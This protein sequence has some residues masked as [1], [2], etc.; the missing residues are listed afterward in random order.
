MAKR[1]KKEVIVTGRFFDPKDGGYWFDVTESDLDHWKQSF[2][3]MAANG[4]TAYFTD[5]HCRTDD[6]NVARIIGFETEKN[7]DGTVGLCAEIE[8]IEGVDIEPFLKKGVSIFVPTSYCGK[9]G[10]NYV[11]PI[12]HVAFT[13]K[14]V[15]ESLGDFRPLC[16]SRNGFDFFITKE[17]GKKM[18]VLNI[19]GAI[20]GVEKGDMSDEDF[21]TA[22]VDAAKVFMDDLLRA[23]EAVDKAA[24]VV[25]EV[26]TASTDG[27]MPIETDRERELSLSLVSITSQLRE[28]TINELLAEGHINNAQRNALVEAYAKPAVL[29]LSKL[30]SGDFEAEI[31]RIKL[32][33]KR[34][35]LDGKSVT[36]V[37]KTG[38]S[39]DPKTCNPGMYLKK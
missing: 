10:T 33:T 3:S 7:D 17:E 1:F 16:L 29:S 9:S 4:D 14:P 39:F 20:Y 34:V 24:E 5:E 21:A 22:I 19:L 6:R 23:K 28:K 35:P 30:N 37:T 26:A 13:D 31:G 27:S 2:D 15:I 36:E 11:T 18:E 8:D 38:D 12:Q 25:D 32:G